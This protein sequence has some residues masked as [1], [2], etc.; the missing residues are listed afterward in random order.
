M[1]RSKN[2]AR[3][4]LYLW[5]FFAISFGIFFMVLEP[6]PNMDDI[7]YNSIPNNLLT[8]EQR[9]RHLVDVLF[10]NDFKSHGEFRTY[11]FSRF[12]QTLL[13]F[14]FAKSHQ[15]SMF[16]IPCIHIMSGYLL[17][18]VLT[19][20]NINSSTA[21]FCGILWAASPFMR[22]ETFHHFSYLALPVYFILLFSLFLLTQ[23]VH[24]EKRNPYAYV[25]GGVLLWMSVFTGEESLPLLGVAICI[26]ILYS[27]L[28]KDKRQ[29][30]I[31]ISYLLLEC[32]YVLSYH[33][34]F[35]NILAATENIRFRTTSIE[36]MLSTIPSLFSTFWDVTLGILQ[37]PNGRESFHN[38]IDVGLLQNASIIIIL[39]FTGVLFLLV[40]LLVQNCLRGK[41]APFNVCWPTKAW[42]VLSIVALIVASYV[43]AAILHTVYGSVIWDRY[44][45]MPNCL[46]LIG[47][48]LILSI[49]TDIKISV[50]F[51]LIAITFSMYKNAEFCAVYRVNANLLNNTVIEQIENAEQNGK[52]TMVV[53]NRQS[54][55]YNAALLNPSYYFAET[56]FGYGWMAGLYIV[57][58][59]ELQGFILCDDMS[60]VYD[61]NSG[62]IQIYNKM[63][64][65]IENKNSEDVFF[66]VL[67]TVA[68]S[69]QNQAIKYL[70]FYSDFN[71]LKFTLMSARCP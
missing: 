48:Y 15:L 9:I 18:K 11:G 8:F 12:L 68:D 31:Y 6:L 59:T 44:L 50:T 67:D 41:F 22:F 45:Y 66:A 1:V 13:T 19:L 47:T 40:Y 2:T 52:T 55:V 38:T 37:L 26:F 17:S 33:Y 54:N 34:Y 29:L 51:Y 14:L 5:L 4:K 43:V 39:A 36:S 32:A 61:E 69:S 53:V 35:K 24:Q 16:L 71:E 60:M 21:L 25:A 63:T 42:Y 30:I 49:L 70:K 46:L 64:N 58:Y 27:I 7:A 57:K 3:R 56:P 65:T 10:N 62:I 20:V 28:I 23:Y